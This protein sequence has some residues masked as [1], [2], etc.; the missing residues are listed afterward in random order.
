MKAFF[1]D[2]SVTF[3]GAVV[4]IIAA[5]VCLTALVI[6]AGIGKDKK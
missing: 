6:A 2:V 5:A 1:Y 4:G 3:I